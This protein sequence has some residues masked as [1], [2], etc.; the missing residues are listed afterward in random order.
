MA[1]QFTEEEIAGYKKAFDVFD[2]DGNGQITTK[3]LGKAMC[4][5]GQNP[6]KAELKEIIRAMD[7]GGNGTIEFQEFLTM[8]TRKMKD[9]HDEE[10]TREL[11]RDFDKDGSGYITAAEVRQ[12][13]AKLGVKLTAEEVDKMI[14]EL[15]ID[16][17]GRINYEGW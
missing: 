9:T 6:T 14:K 8:I 13:M 16:G 10:G 17:D 12:V 11:F 15:D 7:T 1:D 3:E 5:A 4:S 2:H